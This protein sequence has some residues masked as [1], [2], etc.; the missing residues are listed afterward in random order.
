MCSDWQPLGL[1][2]NGEEGEDEGYDDEDDYSSASSPPTS[3]NLR[4][5]MSGSSNSSAEGHCGGNGWLNV[6]HGSRS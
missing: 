4:H 2:E 1:Q 6:R 5:E 3:A